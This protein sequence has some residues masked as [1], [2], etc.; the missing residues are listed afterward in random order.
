MVGFLVISVTVAWGN[1]VPVYESPLFIDVAVITVVFIKPGL[2]INTPA[3]IMVD[4]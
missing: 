4:S 3:V 1:K 2:V